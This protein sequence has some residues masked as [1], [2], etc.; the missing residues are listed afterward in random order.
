MSIELPGVEICCNHCMLFKNCLFKHELSIVHANHSYPGY[1]ELLFVS[2]R[3]GGVE[4][5][6]P[7]E[8]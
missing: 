6:T 7:E 5:G 1:P 8:K 3:K 2:E 4:G